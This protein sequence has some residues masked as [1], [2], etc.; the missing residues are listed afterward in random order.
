MCLLR[1]TGARRVDRED[2]LRPHA[3]VLLEDE[4]A[5]QLVADERTHDRQPGPLRR[6]PGDSGTVSR[7]VLVT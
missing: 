6:L 1:G 5:A 2:D 4:R 7:P 3:V